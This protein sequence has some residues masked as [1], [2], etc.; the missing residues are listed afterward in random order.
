M[1][2]DFQLKPKSGIGLV[3]DETGCQL[4]VASGTGGAPKLI[5]RPAPA[6]T[7]ADPNAPSSAPKASFWLN[8]FRAEIGKGRFR[9]ATAVN[10]RDVFC[11]RISLPSA[12]PAELGQML[13]LQI[14]KLS[15]L[16]M[17]EVVW[18]YE[19]L[20]SEG[21]NS[22]VLVAFA[23]KDKLIERATDFG[24]E[25]LPDLIDVDLMVLWRALRAKKVFDGKNYC[26]LLWIDTPAKTAKCMLLNNSA[27]FLI[28]H[29]PLADA[30]PVQLAHA[31]SMV[32]LGAEANFGTRSVDEIFV[33]GTDDAS[34]ALGNQIGLELGIPVAL[35]PR[36]DDSSAA[37]GLAKR[38]LRNGQAQVNL[39]P[40]DFVERQQRKLFRQQAKRV[41]LV[42]IIVY[43]A[44]LAFF[45]GALSWRKFSIKRIDSQLSQQNADYL[46]ASLL[47]AEVSFLK[48]KIDDRR[49]ALETLRVVTES[50]TEQLFL[51]HFGYKQSQPNAPGTLELR[52]TAQTA[53][54]VYKF[55]DKLQQCGLFAQVKSGSIKGIPSHGSEVSFDVSCLFSG[56]TV[57]AP[58]VAPA[59]ASSSRRGL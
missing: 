15:P 31:L 52:G 34:V 2:L 14:E 48:R 26:A 23:R 11:K 53:D 20:G 4:A 17:E 43:I 16:S 1:K 29:L 50:M 8:Q 36:T 7:N 45:V 42:V 13:S 55:T 39:L 38:A 49:S 44:V 25:F 5:T 51:M 47:Q 40:F 18:S 58:P 28:E 46:K 22:D 6:P 37:M 24:D 57:A 41:G 30:N 12:D 59:A 54:E 33:F 56:G 19:I 21:G 35:L 10:S 9:L 27:P 3:A 32:W